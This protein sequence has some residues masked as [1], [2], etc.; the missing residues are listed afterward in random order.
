[1]GSVV[2]Y[3]SQRYDRGTRPLP[4]YIYLP[5]RLGALQ[6]GDRPGQYAGWLG[7]AYNALATDIRK[8]GEDDNPYFRDCTDE[9]L[10]FHIKG[11]VL[12][13]EMQLD[14]FN[15]RRTLLEQFDTQRRLLEAG[16]AVHTFDSIRQRAVK[17]VTS[18]KMRTA[19]DIRREPGKVR[20]RYGRHLF[21]QSVLMGRRLIEAGS[22]FVTVTWDVPSGYGWDSHRDSHDLKNHLLPGFDQTFSALIGDLEDRGLLDETLVVAIGEMGRTPKANSQWGRGHWTHC[23]PAVLAGAGIRGGMLYGSSDENAAYPAE[24]P[25]RPEDLAATIF[26]ALGLDPQTPFTQREGRPVPL[27][28][29]GRPLTQLFI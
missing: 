1:M 22:R 20:D 24:D 2:E 15:R 7:R 27:V 26:Q 4:D 13:D 14:H 3:L 16:D 29:K 12:G 25:T 19:L 28:E 21:G 23:F 5:N 17:L 6:G 11:I 9:E 10:D 8:R 18:G